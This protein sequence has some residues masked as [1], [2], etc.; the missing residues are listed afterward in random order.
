M[1]LLSPNQIHAVL[2]QDRDEKLKKTVRPEQSELV[3]LLSKHNLTPDEVLEQLSSEMRSG[4][5]AATRLRATETALK[6]NQLLDT[7]GAK[8]DFNVVINIIDGEFS[9]TNPILIPRV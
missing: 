6:L 3:E 8:P 9:G 1:P 4:E 5:S 7:D 2:K